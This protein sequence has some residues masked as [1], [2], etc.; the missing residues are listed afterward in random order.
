MI[1]ETID[2][3]T[4]LA[5]NLGAIAA[6]MLVLWGISIL[7]GDVSFIDAFWAFGFVLVTCVTSRLLPFGGLHQQVLITLAVVWGL[8]LGF[9]LLMRWRR[10][11][12]DGRYLAMISN[13]Q[14][15]VHLYTLR[16]VF[17]LQGIIM[18][19]VSLPLQLGVY[20]AT[21]NLGF[22]G[23]AGLGLA[24]VGIAFESVGDWQ[25]MHFKA[26]PA[27]KGQV[28]GKGLW[29]YTRHP[30]YFGDLC[31]WWGC[32]AVACEAPYGWMSLP[33]PILMTYL[34]VKWSGLALLERRMKHSRP[35]YADYISKTSAFI[36]WPPKKA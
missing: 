20:G 15:N 31:F 18:W 1:F 21:G 24:V 12:P 4:L 7:L 29:R 2:L 17:G 28:L 22:A 35:A 3:P 25:L 6:M 19:I 10:E 16:I 9:H 11:G 32:F 36:P 26:N 5:A 13:A 23:V 14:G 8:R 34:L 30:N 33:G 27:N